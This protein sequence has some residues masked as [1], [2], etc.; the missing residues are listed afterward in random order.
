M[1]KEHWVNEEFWVHV[2]DE[3]HARWYGPYRGQ[4]LLTIQFDPAKSQWI[5]VAH[6]EGLANGRHEDSIPGTQDHPLPAMQRCYE[7]ADAHW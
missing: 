5:C 4:W 3:P 1:A 2:E 6:A 7:M